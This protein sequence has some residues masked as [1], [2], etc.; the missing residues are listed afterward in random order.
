MPLIGGLPAG[1]PVHTPRHSFGLPA[2]MPVAVHCADWSSIPVVSHVSPLAHVAAVLVRQDAP[3]VSNGWQT[4]LQLDGFPGSKLVQ[5]T[6]VL[7]TPVVSQKAPLTQ[8]SLGFVCEI[9]K[10]FGVT[11]LPPMSIS[12]KTL[13][14]NGKISKKNANPSTTEKEKII[15]FLTF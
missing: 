10:A 14:F 15:F 6:A 13:V 2:L 7:V 3:S 9:S 4:P 11:Q 1:G 8:G 5:P 12:A